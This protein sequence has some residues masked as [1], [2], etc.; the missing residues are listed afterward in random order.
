MSN[1]FTWV[2]ASYA[3]HDNMWSHMGGM[4]SMGIGLIHGKSSMNKINT[5][6]TTE[7]ELVS[8]EECLP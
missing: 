4:M 5:K 6:S 2:D 8:A 3:D 1:L 7:D